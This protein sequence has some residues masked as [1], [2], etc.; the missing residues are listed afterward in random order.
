VFVPR[1][2]VSAEQIEARRRQALR[3]LEQGYSLNRVS[4]MVGSAPSSV[5]RWR[6][7]LQ[8]GGEQ[9]LKVRFSPGRPPSLSVAERKKL[10]QRLLRGATASGF[11]SDLWST[12]RVAIVIQRY[13]Q[14][15]FHRSHVVRLM[16]NLGFKCREPQT[17][18]RSTSCQQVVGGDVRARNVQERPRGWVQVAHL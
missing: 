1:P 2:K 17:G 9:A 11:N 15:R 4:R 5:M 16:H 10:V 18:P 13:C 12:Q 8:A 7:T 3:L 6:E 14:A